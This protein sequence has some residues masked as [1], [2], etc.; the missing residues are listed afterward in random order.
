M[1]GGVIGSTE[2][3]DSLNIGSNP[4]RATKLLAYGVIGNVADSDS[5][6]LSSNLSRPAKMR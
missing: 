4:I 1:P 2:D 5:V 6:V 3:F